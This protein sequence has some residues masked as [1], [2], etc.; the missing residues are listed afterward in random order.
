MAEWLTYGSCTQEKTQNLASLGYNYDYIMKNSS[1]G[2]FSQYIMVQLCGFSTY[3]SGL[4]T[5]FYSWH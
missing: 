5:Q 4:Y 3:Y 1:G 2:V